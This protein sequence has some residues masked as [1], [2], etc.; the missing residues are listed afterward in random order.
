MG[1]DDNSD[2]KKRTARA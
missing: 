1:K 2:I